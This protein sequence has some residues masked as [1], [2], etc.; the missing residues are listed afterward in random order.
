MCSPC[1]FI[2]LGFSLSCGAFDRFIETGVFSIGRV[3][4]DF[5]SQYVG[6]KVR[7]VVQILQVDSGVTTGKSTDDCQLIIKGSPPPCPLMSYA[8]VIG[9]ADS[10]QSI[11]VEIWTKFGE[12]FDTHSYNQL[13]QLAN[14]ELKVLFI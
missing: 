13:C 11:C 2:R 7:T 12:T 1:F 14:G 6:R 4:F 8:E 9:I 5:L 3:C 10:E